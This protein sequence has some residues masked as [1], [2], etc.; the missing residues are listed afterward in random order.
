LGGIDLNNIKE[1]KA[2]IGY[3]LGKDYWGQGIMTEAVRLITTYGFEKLGLRRI[4]AHVFVFNKAS[5]TVLKKAG[6]KYEGKL[7]KHAKKGDKF[8]D[9]F[10]FAKVK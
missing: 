9:S 2:E 10:L 8:L 5:M 1:H 4:Y 7:R 3:W 6:F